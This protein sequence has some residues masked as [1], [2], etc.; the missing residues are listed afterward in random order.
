MSLH[1]KTPPQRRPHR[2][3]WSQ[4]KKERERETERQSAQVQTTVF[5]PINGFLSFPKGRIPMNPLPWIKSV[6][7]RACL[8]EPKGVCFQIDIEERRLIVSSSFPIAQSSSKAELVQAPGTFSVTKGCQ[9][10]PQGPSYDLDS[11]LEITY[12][13]W[14]TCWGVKGLGGKEGW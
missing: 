8:L 6:R 11:E 5:E 12:P 10:F 7:S 1:G 14:D 2:G 9:E 3:K 13:P 4:K